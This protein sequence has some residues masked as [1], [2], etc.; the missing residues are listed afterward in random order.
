MPK[1][2]V[3]TNLV[4]LLCLSA[5]GGSAVIDFLGGDVQLGR[6]AFVWLTWV[7]LGCAGIMVVTEILTGIKWVPVVALGS[8]VY[9]WLAM[10]DRE[11]APKGSE[12]AWALGWLSVATWFAYLAARARENR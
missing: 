5:L 6:S 2:I 8:L 10:G 11:A 1:T 12:I 4:L 7:G 3:V 9:G